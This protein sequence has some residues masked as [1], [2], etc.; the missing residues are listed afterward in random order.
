M[1]EAAIEKEV[2]MVHLTINNIPV[3]VPKGTKIMQAA[4]KL[5]IDIPH[6]CYHE[7]QKIKAHCR[8]CSVEVVGKRRLLAAC[9]TECWEGM[10]VHTDTQ[11]VR[12]TQVSI[13]QLMLANHNK[14]CLSCPRN[15][16]CDL[17][18]LCSRFNILKSPLPSVVK[19]T[20]RIETNPSIVRDPSKCIRCGRCIRA[21]KDVQGIAALTY[22]HRSSDIVVTTAYNKPM[23]A[24][25]CILCGQ[26]SLVCPTGAIVEKDDTQ[27]VLDALQNPKKHVIVQ[28]AP[29]VRVSIGDA[30]GLEPGAISTGQMVTALKLLGFDKVFDTNFGADLTIMEESAEFVQ[31][32]TKGGVLPMMTS[33]SPGWV[34]YMEKHYGDLRD[35]LSSAKSPMSMFGAIA[36]TYYPE[37]AGV[38]VHDIV[39]VAIM[40]CTAK[41][42]EAARPEMGRDGM[43][44]VDVVLTTRELIKLIKYVGLEFQ[45]LPESDFDSPLGFGTGAGA[46]FGA[47]GGVM[48]AALRTAY[49]KVTG[50]TL[51]KLD[52]DD[53]RGFEGIKETTVDLGGKTV[54]I[55]VAH[56][57]RNARLIMEQI[58]QGTCKYDFIEIMACPGGCIGGG[59]QPIGTTNAVRKKRMAALYQIDKSL[60]LRKSHENPEIIT[61]YKDFL[62]EPLSEKA[63][64]LLHTTYHKV[65]RPYEF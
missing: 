5:G 41:K 54:R 2:P 13:L 58:K 7:D 30:F 20:P 4:L 60:P 29:A 10:E 39:T 21:C 62:G 16:N 57:L 49:E 24:T 25:D 22:A 32:L 40:P 43:R 9:S 65:D 34:N 61:L 27:K 56:T 14:D 11:I 18:R 55:A 31:R 47:S 17:Q 8:L 64:E 6:L 36:K 12:D 26:C 15:Q 3:E 59:G 38:D 42:F 44:D 48:E 46:I 63:H 23:E 50:K 33:C 51:E 1:S 28:V 19:I 53:V 52:F 35:H 45:Q 37:H